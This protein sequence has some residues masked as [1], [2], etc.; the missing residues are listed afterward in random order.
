LRQSNDVATAHEQG[1]QKE[2]QRIQ[3]DLHDDV[4]A[5]LLTLLHQTREPVIKKVAQNALRGLRDV[6]YLLGAEEAM[7]NDVM[8][9][10][11]AVTREQ[12]SGLGIYFECRSP[13]QWPEVL[14]NSQ[15]HINLLRISREAIANAIKHAHADKIIFDFRIENYLL[16]MKFSNN[17]LISQPDTWVANRGL[18][19]IK[20]RVLEM[21]ASHKW[22]IEQGDGN[23][24]YCTLEV[25]VPL[26]PHGKVE[27]NTA[28]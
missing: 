18:N 6:I 8:T 9:D 21:E 4:A 7:L 3:R 17:G 5:R 28:Y 1:V 23:N 16:Y 2:R 13:D 10:I 12:V 11:Q 26:G 24:R 20:S 22:V 15:T 14:L 27:A 25:I 19:N